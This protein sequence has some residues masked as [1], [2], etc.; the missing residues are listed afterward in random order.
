MISVS[1][2]DSERSIV[3]EHIETAVLSGEYSIMEPDL[4]DENNT[5]FR[6]LGYRVL[7]VDGIGVK[8]SWNKPLE[9]EE[10]ES[11]IQGIV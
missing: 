3:E 9:I 8:I 10:S 7:Y 4:L 11:V 1:S 6:G 5:Y 2:V